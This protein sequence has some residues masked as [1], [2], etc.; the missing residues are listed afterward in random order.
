MKD[1]D[2]PKYE[3]GKTLKFA[4]ELYFCSIT[5]SKIDILKEKLTLFI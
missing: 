5:E 3:R 4:H 1:A 2:G